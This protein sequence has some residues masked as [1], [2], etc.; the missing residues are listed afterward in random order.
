MG[1]SN[2]PTAITKVE[3]FLALMVEANENLEWETTDPSKLAY[4]IREGIS[5]SIIM[6]RDNPEDER[7]K[8]FSELKSKFILKIK[9]NHVIA[10]LR[11]EIPLAV[12]S[13]K[14]LK[15]V[16]LPNITT[17]TEIVGAVAK[18]IIEERKEQIT[19]PNS[20]LFEDELKKL[21]A[22]L[23]SKELKIEVNENEL[24]I[25]KSTD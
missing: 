22:Y 8:G 11:S 2:N 15:S 5:A 7:F 25:S 24:V 21:E 14:K 18:Y 16:Y 20:D 6:Y 17:L 23:K 10:A 3:R 1:Y 13:V 4:Y 12:M 19:I 9:S